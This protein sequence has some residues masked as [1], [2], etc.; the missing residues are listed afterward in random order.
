MSVLIKDTTRKEREEIIKNGLALA[1]LDS[2][3]PTEKA[4]ALFGKYING[5][6]EL[7][8]VETSIIASYSQN[9]G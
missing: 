4:M 7:K 9:N 8:E 5:E 1:S 2:K 6:M 3:P